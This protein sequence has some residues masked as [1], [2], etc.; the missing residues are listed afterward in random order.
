MTVIAV[1]VENEWD[2]F[3]SE[4][5]NALACDPSSWTYEPSNYGVDGVELVGGKH[6][7]LWALMEVWQ[8]PGRKFGTIIEKLGELESL[9]VRR[10]ILTDK[11]VVYYDVDTNELLNGDHRR[12]VSSTL[13]I[14]GWMAQGV[15]FKDDAA[16]LRFSTVSNKREEE[17][18][19]WS[20]PDAD[21][22]EQVVRELMV[23]YEVSKIYTDEDIKNEVKTLGTGAVS[24]T[25]LNKIASKLIAEKRYSGPMSVGDRFDTFSDE[26]FKLFLLNTNDPW[27]D[28]VYN[29]PSEFCVYVNDKYWN[30][31]I[32]T[33]ITYGALAAMTKRPLHLLLSFDFKVLTQ[34]ETSR[35]KVFEEKLKITERDICNLVGI[36]FDRFGGTATFAWNHPDCQHRALPQASSENKL[37]TVK[38]SY[39]KE[40]K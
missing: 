20:P 29:E 7:I 21:S 11:P 5:W 12:T 16:K 10:G 40:K 31:K 9:I 3:I 17:E 1:K 32:G 8:N 19:V 14:P 13:D 18:D 27:I 25:K 28:E 26:T 30:S 33:L 4:Y 15:R 6:M 39:S 2:S 22:I 35:R 38:M 24:D 36:D 37:Q 34:I 23:M